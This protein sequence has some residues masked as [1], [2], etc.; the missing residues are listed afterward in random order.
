MLLSLQTG[1]D[2]FQALRA[3]RMNARQDQCK[4][5]MG[6]WGP[7]DAR[8]LSRAGTRYLCK[9][10]VLAE[11]LLRARTGQMLSMCLGRAPASLISTAATCETMCGARCLGL[12]DS[13]IVTE[14]E[15]RSHILQSFGSHGVGGA[16][17]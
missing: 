12:V 1:V 10:L 5:L 9:G 2:E 16:N 17:T 3:T 11:Q 4:M 13:N 7:E 15:A 14:S 8:R 6:M